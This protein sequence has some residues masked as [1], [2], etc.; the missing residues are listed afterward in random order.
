MKVL[1]TGATGFVGTALRRRLKALGYDVRVF[2][3]PRSVAKIDVTEGLEI[4]AGD[5]LDSHACLRVTDGVDA[6]V[7]LVGIRREN[8]EVGTTYEALHTEATFNVADAARRQG[9]GRFIYLSGLGARE[10]ARSRYH[11]TKWESEGV[12]QRTGMRWTI[13]RPSVIFGPGDEFH[14][15]VADLVQ[16]R[17]V[18]IV[19]GGRSLLQPVSIENVVDAL[20]ASL[21]TPE[22]QGQVYE[23]GGPDRVPF[24][25]IVTRVA[26]HLEVWPNYANVSS[27]L[28][29]P[30]VKMLQRCRSFPLTY[31]ELL[32]M[33]E[34]NV[35]DTGPV[36]ATFGI[37]LDGYLEH[38]D[39][40]LDRVTR[41]AA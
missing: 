18:P 12:V 4:V 39:A 9:V 28:M 14:P 6:V 19:D 26:R 20:A 13:F 24:I 25:D 21:S 41:Y 2:V 3:R 30:M 31:D 22:S 34:D 10:N 15:L 16:R 32:M 5:V 35:C 8:R 36:T 23:M 27:R 29:K 11:L 38:L 33:L 37:T 1:I 7:H 40:L 17:V